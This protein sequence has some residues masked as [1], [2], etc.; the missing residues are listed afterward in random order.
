MNKIKINSPFSYQCGNHS[1]EYNTGELLT[2]PGQ[3][4]APAELLRRFKAGMPIMGQEPIYD[5][6]EF[7][8]EDDPRRLPDF[9]YTDV[10]EYIEKVKQKTK[11]KKEE[12]SSL[13]RDEEGDRQGAPLRP[14]SAKLSSDG[15]PEEAGAGE[16]KAPKRPTESSTGD[17]FYST[18]ERSE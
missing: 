18:H 13:K 15:L 3:S 14:G 4:M 16:A 8:S 17:N 12:F 11:N 1:F 7:D 10:T 6:D 5:N 2:V 9:D